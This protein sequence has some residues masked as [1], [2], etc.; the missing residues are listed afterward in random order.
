MTDNPDNDTLNMPDT[1]QDQPE[2]PRDE[3]ASR[4]AESVHDRF[5]CHGKLVRAMYAARYETHMRVVQRKDVEWTSHPR[6]DGG[7]FCGQQ[8]Q[9]IWPQVARFIRG[10][11]LP[12]FEFIEQKFALCSHTPPAPNDLL[13]RI[14]VTALRKQID[15]HRREC[16][17]QL[18][19]ETES[20]KLVVQM[21]AAGSHYDGIV[22]PL[23][24]GWHDTRTKL[25]LYCLAKQAGSEPHIE[26]YREDAIK[27]Y[28]RKPHAYHM[29]WASILPRGIFR[30]AL[31]FAG[32]QLPPPRQRTATPLGDDTQ[33]ATG[34]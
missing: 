31:R 10:L 25:Y 5:V 27:Q 29:E 30:D 14:G 22:N 1:P 19:Y 26:A 28:L 12:Y 15:E 9:S 23:T 11:R 7:I 34:T 6:W 24:E 17:Y 3:S 20:H 4:Q 13:L 8:Y 32:V 2:Q 16:K 33:G 18:W 21:T